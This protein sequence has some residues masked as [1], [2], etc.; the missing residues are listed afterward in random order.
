MANFPQ[1]PNVQNQTLQPKNAQKEKPTHRHVEL[2]LLKTKN[3]E[4]MAPHKKDTDITNKIILCVLHIYH[5]SI[6][7]KYLAIC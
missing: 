4:T 5:V 1:I 7:Y 2:K 3:K 6:I